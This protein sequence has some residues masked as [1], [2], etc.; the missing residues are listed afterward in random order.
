MK[1]I[2]DKENNVEF[3]NRINN[4]SKDSKPQWGKM[5]DSQMLAHC[6]VGIKVAFGEI[7]IK[8]AFM[9]IIFGSLA[10]KILVSDKPFRKNTPTAKEFI[11]KGDKN[12]EVEKGNLIKYV[13]RFTEVGESVLRKDPHP[14]FGN[15]TTKEWDGLMWK[16]L[17]HHLRQ[18]G[19]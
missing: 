7:K 14:F 5:N 13:K 15:L 11:I 10:K 18:F 12:F 19:V 6:M 17:D 4:L 16:H 3:I 2:F 9:G 1:S 8:R